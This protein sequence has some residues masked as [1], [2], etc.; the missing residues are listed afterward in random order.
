[1]RC[2]SL[3]RMMVILRAAAAMNG[4]HMFPATRFEAPDEQ[5][6]L[7][8]VVADDGAVHP[9][10]RQMKQ[11]EVAAEAQ[12]TP[13]KPRNEVISGNRVS[14]APRRE[15]PIAMSTPNSGSMAAMI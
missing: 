3:L 10:H 5:R 9:D 15:S 8:Y 1:M 2:T 4:Q 12:R 11:G 14:P 6:T 7:E 13:I